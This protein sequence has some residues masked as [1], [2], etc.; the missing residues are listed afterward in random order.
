MG[1]QGVAIGDAVKFGVQSAWLIEAVGLNTAWRHLPEHY[2][3]LVNV[4]FP[5]CLTLFIAMCN[6]IGS[7]VTQ[8]EVPPIIQ[9]VTQYPPHNEIIVNTAVQ[10]NVTLAENTVR[11]ARVYLNYSSDGKEWTVYQLAK[12]GK[13]LWS[14]QIPSFPPGSQVLYTIIAENDA[15]TTKFT[16]TMNYKYSYPVMPEFPSL[17]LLLILLLST[18]VLVFLKKPLGVTK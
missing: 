7:D 13:T 14:C 12:I 16:E 5:K 6:L 4:Y 8:V 18:A 9:T 10:V 17:T 11:T 3:E 1:A 15:G 2:D